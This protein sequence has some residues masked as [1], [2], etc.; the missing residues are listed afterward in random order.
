MI[1]FDY[2]S[3]YLIDPR[4]PGRIN[5]TLPNAKIIM[6][7][8]NPVD[9]AYMHWLEYNRTKGGDKSS[10]NEGLKNEMQYLLPHMINEGD[11]NFDGF[12]KQ[13]NP[14]M[15]PE[16]E[17]SH[18]SKF[19]P[20]QGGGETYRASGLY[21][22]Q[23]ERWLNNNNGGGG[24][25]SGSNDDDADNLNKFLFIS[26]EELISTPDRVLGEIQKFLE[27]PEKFPPFHQMQDRLIKKGFLNLNPLTAST[28]AI[29]GETRQQ[30][31]LFFKPFNEKLFK[32]LGKK[33]WW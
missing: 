32:L 21:Y 7:L 25:G 3:N 20:Q 4:V 24:G 8:R 26:Y 18:I 19:S 11:F 33:F 2:S 27:L 9:R 13:I 10:F 23:I 14:T 28:N 5:E 17:T 16:L 12:W 22:Y 15:F 31:E 6:I 30:L 1:T 29:D